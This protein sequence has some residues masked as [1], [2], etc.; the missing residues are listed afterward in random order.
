[1][2]IDENTQVILSRTGYTGEK[3]F[4]VQLT[5]ATEAEMFFH[6][7]LQNG[8]P[9]GMQPIG[10]G[11]RDT[12]RLEKCF[13]LAS[14]EFMDGRTPLEAGLG[15]LINW[16]HDFVG[17]DALLIQKEKQYDQMT[18][19][20]CDDKGIP[21]QGSPVQ[22]KGQKVGIVSSGTVSPC[23]NTGIAMA[24]VNQDYRTIGQNLEILIRGKPIKA[25]VVKMPFVKKGEC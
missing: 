21:R 5:S 18:Y 10:L 16:N 7:I 1:M 2:T 17:K 13:A 3:G 9:F 11:A 24:Y 19:L 20:K 14:N 12:L 25:S 15:W 8:K 22:Y 4:E 6:S 23:L